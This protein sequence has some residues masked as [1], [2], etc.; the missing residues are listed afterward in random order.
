MGDLT[1]SFERQE[2]VEAGAAGDLERIREALQRAVR[3]FCP[4]WL[5]TDREDLVQAA[6]VRVLQASKRSGKEPGSFEA[7][8]LWRVAHSAV[9]DEI[10][11]RRREGPLD[12]NSSPSAVEDAH[13]PESDLRAAL[14]R[15]AIREGVR[16][17]SP[18]RQGAVML[19]L[20]GFSLADS[21]R[22]LGWNS[23]RVD[24]QRYQGLAELR[25]YLEK[26]GLEP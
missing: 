16:T 5:A 11:R 19:Y 15:E 14:V 17:L 26:R 1:R 20:H 21:A 9:M 8:Y 23:K 2:M 12:V 24:N 10:R 25:R 4:R 13:D 18:A 7:S 3:R 22:I 6:C